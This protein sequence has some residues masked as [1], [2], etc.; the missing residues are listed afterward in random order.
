[1]APFRITT[2]PLLA[3]PLFAARH[4]SAKL[5]RERRMRLKDDTT[6]KEDLQAGRAWGNL[7]FKVA[8]EI[9]RAMCAAEGIAAL[10]R[11][12]DLV[13]LADYATDNIAALDMRVSC[14]LVTVWV[15]ELQ[16]P[17]QVH[18]FDGPDAIADAAAWCRQRG[19]A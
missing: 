7:G 12:A 5:G 1:L 16:A 15:V 10:Q 3:A 18:E 2:V 13:T 14:G 8:D 17:A 9:D 19:G 4:I 6:C 11:A